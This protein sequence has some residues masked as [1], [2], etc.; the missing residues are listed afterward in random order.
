MAAKPV[1][2]RTPSGLWTFLDSRGRLMDTHVRRMILA[3]MTV[4]L[5]AGGC[6]GGGVSGPGADL[7][8]AARY[9]DAVVELERAS[10]TQPKNA[11]LKR[12]LGIAR[13]K[14]GDAKGAVVDLKAARAQAAKDQ[15]T[16]FFL[17]QA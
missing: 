9:H 2:R 11:R 4:V 8:N 1:H 14:D 10:A 13:F 7:M 5:V 16:L 6:A 15:P 3:G 12:N 17:A